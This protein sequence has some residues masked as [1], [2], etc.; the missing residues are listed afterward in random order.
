MLISPFSSG[1]AEIFASKECTNYAVWLRPALAMMGFTFTRA[2]PIAKDNASAI[3][4]CT[5]TK[6]HSRQRHFRM[7]INLLRDCCNRRITSYPWVPTKQMKGA[8]FNKMSGRMDHE[9]SCKLKGIYAEELRYVA[10]EQKKNEL[11]GRHYINERTRTNSARRKYVI[12]VMSKHFRIIW[13][14]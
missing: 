14:C 2:T 12:R 11:D 8:L 3:A 6:H 5:G 7:Q 9:R 4:T 10:D 1:E 13:R